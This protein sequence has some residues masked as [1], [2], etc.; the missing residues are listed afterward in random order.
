LGRSP[1]READDLARLLDPEEV[2]AELG[3]PIDV[4]V[5]LRLVDDRAC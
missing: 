2:E 3:Q 5:Q 4:S 1:G